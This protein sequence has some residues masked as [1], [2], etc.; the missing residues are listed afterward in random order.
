[1]G[2]QPSIRVGTVAVAKQRTEVCAFGEVGVCYEM[3]RIGER[4]GWSFI[5][6][7]GRYDGFSPNDVERF[8]HI[9]DIICLSVAGYRFRNVTQLGEDFTAG[10]FDAA[11]H[12]IGG[13]SSDSPPGDF[14]YCQ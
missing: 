10:Y 3:Y 8:L 1:M 2:D 14:P 11:F 7:S 12:L 6:R 4:P 13:S 9:T 5:F